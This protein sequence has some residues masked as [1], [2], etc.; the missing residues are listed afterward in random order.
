MIFL[1]YFRGL[2]LIFFI[3]KTPYTIKKSDY[4]CESIMHVLRDCECALE[5]WEKIV[6]PN[7]WHKFASL[8]LHPWLEFNLSNSDVGLGSW[9]WPIVFGTMV[10]MLWIDRNHFVFLGKSSIPDQFLPKVFGQVEAIHRE[11]MKPGPSF[12][13][14]SHEISVKWRPP[15]DGVISLNVDGSHRQRHSACGGLLRNS[16]G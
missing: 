7:Q 14:D 1:F 9:N 13:E 16:T 5:L 12:I 10:H 11:L 2:R 8:G 15:P 3:F 4:N 6:D